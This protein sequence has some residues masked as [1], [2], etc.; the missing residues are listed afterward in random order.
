MFYLPKTS[1][2]SQAES[3]YHVRIPVVGEITES[4]YPPP[5]VVSSPNT[6]KLTDELREQIKQSS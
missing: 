6:R 4:P 5:L 3:I 1:N 2:T